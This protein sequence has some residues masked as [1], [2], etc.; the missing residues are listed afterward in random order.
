MSSE[1]QLLGTCLSGQKL[2]LESVVHVMRHNQGG[3]YAQDSS[4]LVSV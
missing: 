1:G 2:T 4:P 3:F